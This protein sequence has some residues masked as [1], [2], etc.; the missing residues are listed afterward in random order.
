MGN[1]NTVEWVK[2]TRYN[3]KNRE[4]VVV[5]RCCGEYDGIDIGI[6]RCIDRGKEW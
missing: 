6:K 2:M 1:F 3:K 5:C 4:G